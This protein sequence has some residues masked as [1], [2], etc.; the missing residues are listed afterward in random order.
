MTVQRDRP[1]N[2]ARLKKQ[3]TRRTDPILSRSPICGSP[4][5]LAICLSH[6]P[7]RLS[8]Q[9][10]PLWH[11]LIPPLQPI[12]CSLSLRHKGGQ[13]NEWPFCVRNAL[14]VASYL[15]SFSILFHWTRDQVPLSYLSKTS[16][17]NLFLKCWR[18]IINHLYICISCQY[19]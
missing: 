7:T 14:M 16:W 9:T 10:L 2:S 12:K 17:N 15:L 4:T 11:L 19:T 13:G 8:S 18:N 5:S 6:G 3:T 1:V